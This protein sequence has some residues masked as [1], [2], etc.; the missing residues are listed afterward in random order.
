MLSS[1]VVV[2]T[3]TVAVLAGAG[4]HPN[5]FRLQAPVRPG[6]SGGPVV[7]AEGGL[8]GVVVAGLDA[9]KVVQ[10]TGDIPQNVDRAIEAGVATSF[11]E[12]HG[13]ARRGAGE[14]AGESAETVRRIAAR[15]T[16]GPRSGGRRRPAASVARPRRLRS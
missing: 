7:D 13:L 8:V 15:V 14:E 6:N 2:A 10:A 11:L 5:L 9:P 16:C 12:A 3:G 1:R 4:D